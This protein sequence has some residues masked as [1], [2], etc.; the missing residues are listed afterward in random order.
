MFKFALFVI[1]T[2]SFIAVSAPFLYVDFN[3]FVK[4]CLCF[5]NHI[6]FHVINILQ[7]VFTSITRDLQYFTALEEAY[8]PLSPVFNDSIV[9][10][11]ADLFSNKDI[12]FLKN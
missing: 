1:L 5:P 2:V 11:N 12:N 7:K 8:E 9:I 10:D 4:N 6:Y 3:W